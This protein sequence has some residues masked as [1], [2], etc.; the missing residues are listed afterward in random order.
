MKGLPKTL[1]SKQDYIYAKDNFPESY[2]KP[3]YQDLLDSRNA[4]FCIGLTTEKKGVTDET[5][6]VVEKKPMDEGGKTEY[7][8]YE[9]RENQA[10]K[11]FQIGF[12]VKE[13]EDALNEGGK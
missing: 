13:V 2:W 7:Y 5:H 10:C 9:L 11:L 3:K 12:T 8:Q 4:W 1:N 6:K